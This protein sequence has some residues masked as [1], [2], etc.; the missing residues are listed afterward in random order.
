MQQSAKNEL[1]PAIFERSPTAW[2]YENEK[3]FAFSFRA[4]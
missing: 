4:E 2:P 1:F 3:M